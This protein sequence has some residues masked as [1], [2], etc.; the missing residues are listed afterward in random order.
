MSDRNLPS[1]DFDPGVAVDNVNSLKNDDHLTAFGLALMQNG[2][3]TPN[4]ILNT[5]TFHQI[6]KQN[7]S[8]SSN[9]PA[10]NNQPQNSGN[11]LS[12]Q[13]HNNASNGNVPEKP[14]H[15]GN[16]MAAWN[17]KSENY[18]Q[19]Q[20][21]L[22]YEYVVELYKN[23][24]STLCFA[25][26]FRNKKQEAREN[27]INGLNNSSGSLLIGSNSQTIQKRYNCSTCPYST[28]RRDLF[29]RHENIHKEDKPFHCYVCLKQFNRADHV[30]K[31]F[32]RMHRG[33]NYD[34]GRTKRSIPQVNKLLSIFIF[35]Y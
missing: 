19:S 7:Q 15:H 8:N 26:Y 35:F 12:V 18:Q 5:H 22:K 21:I 24:N 28:D 17:T 23:Q 20:K 33:L 29:T 4:A 30:K 2:F 14:V 13:G 25:F 32:L 1:N 9:I 34:I 3:P 10:I 6:N 31:H 27:S 11:I 16:E